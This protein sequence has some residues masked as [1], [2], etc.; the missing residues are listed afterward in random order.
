MKPKLIAIT[1]GD[2]AG[3]GPEVIKHWLLENPQQRH[4]VHL[5]G[6]A[7]WL[8]ATGCLSPEQ[9]SSV[10][11]EHYRPV[12]GQPTLAGAEVARDALEAAAMGCR[13]GLYRAVVTGPVSKH[14]M[15]Q[16]G[17]PYPGQTEFFADRWH[18]T[19]V[20]AFA[21]GKLTVVL[22]TWHIPLEQVPGSL[23]RAC[24]KRAVEAAHYLGLKR[25]ILKPRIGVCGLNPHAG[26]E[27]L[28]GWEE[29]GPDPA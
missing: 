16:V 11:S 8:E 27:G 22:A 29:N 15:Q 2:P 7:A 28:L 18:G 19:P 14:W 1:C 5:I 6:P 9:G 20:M 21:G 3:L 4:N 25:G 24:I 17:W 13:Q 26:E 10:G 12:A 23:D